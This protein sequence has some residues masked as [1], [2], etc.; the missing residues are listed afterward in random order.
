MVVFKKKHRKVEIALSQN[1]V[2][3]KCLFFKSADCD[4]YNDEMTKLISN[5]EHQK[6]SRISKSKNFVPAKCPYVLEHVVIG[7]S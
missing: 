5:G 7:G 4:Y 1:K 6:A 3:G 2:C